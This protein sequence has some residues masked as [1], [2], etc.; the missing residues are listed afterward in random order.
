MI[1][2]EVARRGIE[3]GAR[4]LDV[5]RVGCREPHESG[6]RDVFRLRRPWAELRPHVAA[7]PFP[8]NPIQIRELLGARVGHDDP[9]WKILA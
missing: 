1:D 4:I 5:C 7:K 3:K 2:D 8:V 9:G 6:L